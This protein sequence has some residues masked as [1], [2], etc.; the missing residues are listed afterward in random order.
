M[1][2]EF[3]EVGRRL[4]EVDGAFWLQTQ[5]GE[6]N[7]VA[8]ATTAT[9][10]ETEVAPRTLPPELGA[11][12]I[13][14][15][16]IM[17]SVQEY[18]RG[19]PPGCNEGYSDFDT[20]V[21]GIMTSASLPEAEFSRLVANRTG[22]ELADLTPVRVIATAA[23]EGAVNLAYQKLH[24]ENTKLTIGRLAGMHVSASGVEL[25]VLDEGVLDIT[26]I[27]GLVPALLSDA[28]SASKVV[29]EELLSQDRELRDAAGQSYLQLP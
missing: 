6:A 12:A 15:L 29:F 25:R 3:K 27:E 16:Q 4:S 10:G 1:M 11:V 28:N 18:K 14:Y 9:D 7:A 20:G 13:T 21:A 24:P 23:E 26:A 17:S 19:H 8:L 2:R 5:A 22:I